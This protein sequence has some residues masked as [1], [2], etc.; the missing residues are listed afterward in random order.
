MPFNVQSIT[1]DV[2]F[3]TTGGTVRR[4][5]LSDFC[6][7]RRNGL[8]AMKLD[9]GEAIV[10]VATATEHDDILL[11]TR[12]GQCIR[13]AVP[14]VRVFQGRT[15]MGVRGVTLAADDGFTARLAATTRLSVVREE[16]R[17]F[18]AGIEKVVVNVSSAGQA[19]MPA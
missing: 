4:N 1:L 2:I 19:C 5:K 17:A 13:F 14:E 9:A 6:D 8:I 18:N 3:A 11:T 15:S 7:V 10:D 12:A 16:P